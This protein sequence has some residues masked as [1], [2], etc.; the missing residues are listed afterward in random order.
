[1]ISLISSLIPS[2][3]LLVLGAS[4]PSPVAYRVVE[5]QG[6]ARDVSCLATIGDELWVGTFGSGVRRVGMKG[7]GERYDSSRGLPGNRVYDCEAYMGVLW[8]ATEGGLAVYA[9]GENR[10]VTVARGRFLR[11]ASAESL[12]AVEGDGMVKVVDAR[13]RLE[14]L[15]RVATEVAPLSAAA[16]PD[17]RFAVGGV[18]GRVSV[19]PGGE[20]ERLNAPVTS[21]AYD[22]HELVAL[23]PEGGFRLIDGEFQPDPE[24]QDAVLLDER[25]RPVVAKGLEW[26]RVTSAALWQGRLH[27]GTD[28][29]VFVSPPAP[30]G[31]DLK[32]ETRNLKPRWELLALGGC[33]CGP[34]LSAMAV[35]RGKLWVGSFDNGL[36]RLDK[37]GWTHFEGAAFLPSDMVNHMT[38]SRRRLYVATLKGIVVIDKKGNFTQHTVEQCFDNNKNPCPWH[39]SVTGVAVDPVTGRAWVADTGAVHRLG[40]TRWKHFYKH[41]GIKSDRVTRIAARDD[42]I[43]VGTGDMG[44][45]WRNGA[46][47]KFTTVDDQHGPAD[48]WV[49]DVEFDGAGALWVATCTRGISRYFDGEWSSL[50]VADGL[51]DDY[52]L[53]VSEIDSRIWVGT[54]SGVTILTE[55]GPVTLTTAEGLSGDEVHDILKYDDKIYLATDGG[56][57]IIEELSAPRA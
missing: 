43:A 24:L 44:L 12:F 3:A 38:A 25:A 39:A 42:F 26:V 40:S 14:P 9:P 49:M 53:A 8:V 6:S 51:V 45:H 36:C 35:F 52:T 30:G 57:T 47:K 54:L 50:T 13:E 1:M 23:T 41:S 22:G 37:T 7:A 31:N 56:L 27:V 17:G 19:S 55:T 33:P 46:G 48:N 2:L 20:H 28:E 10:F 18:D 4:F 21:L 16:G 5:T 15:S 29:G 11:L 34:R 32:P